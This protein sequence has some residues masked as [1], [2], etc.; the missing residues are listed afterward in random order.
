MSEKYGVVTNFDATKVEET[1]AKPLR[2][3][4]DVANLNRC[5]TCDAQ[6]HVTATLSRQCP[7]CGTLPFE[8]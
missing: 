1:E 6:I 8:R 5:P 7:N 2:R 3:T 4:A